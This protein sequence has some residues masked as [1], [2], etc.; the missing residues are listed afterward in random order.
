[1]KATN[2]HDIRGRGQGPGRFT[3]LLML[4]LI[5]WAVPLSAQDLNDN[6]L[7][8]RIN[9]VGYVDYSIPTG[10]EGELVFTLNGGDG[11][12]RVVPNLCIKKGGEGATARLIFAV[13]DGPNKL[14]P[15]GTI[16]FVIGE[17]GQSLKNNRTTAGGG[18]GG[19]A[20]L[21]KAPGASISC[22]D[23]IPSL[24][25]S[26]ANNCWVILGVA[27]G[28]GG[29][30]ASGLCDGAAGQG[31][32]S[33]TSGGDGAGPSGGTGGTGGHG[34]IQGSGSGGG[35]GYLSRG[36]SN[37]D[38]EGGAGYF[39]GGAGGFSGNTNEGGFGYGGGGGHGPI[40]AGGGGGFSGGGGGG[41]YNRGGGGGSF[42]NSAAIFSEIEGGGST[43]RPRNGYVDYQFQDITITKP[44]SIA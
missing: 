11:G 18:G 40:A 41:A 13:G 9:D 37:G 27:G 26:N 6:G 29:A 31:G 5:S 23:E 39:T 36:T 16:R 15:G 34:G 21:Y 1:M 42:A 44:L 30:Y 43:R 20:V 32:R 22:S 3:F 28:G 38:G 35:G 8:Y 24:N 17:K 2:H 33:G 14:K 25:L 7:P 4:F 12:R 19:T 10:I